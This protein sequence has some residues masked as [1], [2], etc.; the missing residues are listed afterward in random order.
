M[1]SLTRVLALGLILT[2]AGARGADLVKDE[3]WCQVAGP[4]F[5]V[6]SQLKA[7]DTAVWA[8]RVNQFVKAMEGRLP[9]DRRALG[10]LTL[11]LFGSR[12]DFWKAAPVLNDGDPLKGLAEFTRS[13]GWGAT[14]AAYDDGTA[15][16]TQRMVLHG[17]A[18]WLL[19]AHH[20]YVPRA[21]R[22]GLGDVYGAYVIE[23][24]R[25]VLGRPLRNW[26][27]LLRRAAEHPLSTNGRFLRVD[28]LLAVRDMNP[29]ADKHG[30]SIFMVESWGF[31]HFL[32][33]SK[34]MAERHAMDRLLKAFARRES[35]KEALK[36]AF[37]DDAE[38]INSLFLD[39]IR[40][41][42]F[43]ETRR[44]IQALA[45][46]ADPV[47][48]SQALVAATLARV[49]VGARRLEAARAYAERA[50]ALSPDDPRSHDALALVAFDEG[51]HDDVA[52]EC[53]KGMALNTRDGW[54][55]YLES[56]EVGRPAGG[57]PV[58][59]NRL[60]A[61]EA[62]A[63]MNASEMAIAR[64]KGL[65]PAYDRV[66]ALVP[67]ADKVTE[68]DGR[69]LMLGTIL[70]PNDGFIEIGRAQWAHRLHEKALA[71]HILDGVLAR[72]DWYAPS[73]AARAR[74]LRSAWSGGS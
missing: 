34:D 8:N 61:E 14:V 2:G 32:L 37:G 27:S 43:Y 60:T 44:P 31:V 59:P 15:E 28:E 23:N 16:D 55:W 24:G 9:G 47:P 41:G 4:G 5:T 10:P 74:S 6:V 64:L 17:A 7:S 18:D 68:D 39:Y 13:G 67:F 66:A 70:V 45:P 33:F 53:G 12:S 36:L 71:L 30:A 54:T 20:P 29:V 38:S 19:S 11:V 42:D 26:T 1:N 69:F 62:R 56:L 72:S 63:A 22:S 50:A 35:P 3:G 25:E 21:L 57:K 51:R 73:V 52:A 46:L 40:G 49:E 48:A 65:Q 58:P